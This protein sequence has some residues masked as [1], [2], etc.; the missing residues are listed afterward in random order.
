MTPNTN[1]QL[2]STNTLKCTCVNPQVGTL[3]YKG[4]IVNMELYQNAWQDEIE[5]YRFY[6]NAFNRQ[7]SLFEIETLEVT[8]HVEWLNE[9]NV[10]TKKLV[11]KIEGENKA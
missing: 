4:I 11:H 1:H 5:A 8:N 6:I 3:N 10:C 7:N 9:C 2:Q